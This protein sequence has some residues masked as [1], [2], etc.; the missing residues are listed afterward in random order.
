MEAML[1]SAGSYNFWLSHQLLE[2]QRVVSGPVESL[3][4]NEFRRGES[5]VRHELLIKLRGRTEVFMIPV[6]YGPAIP[7]VLKYVKL[8]DSITAYYPK[9]AMPSAR[10]PVGLIHLV[11]KRRVLLDFY[12][13]QASSRRNAIICAVG[14]GLGG[15][16][17]LLGH[18][19]RQLRRWW[20]RSAGSRRFFA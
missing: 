10:K 15:V 12:K 8:G 6:R 11:H 17:L 2:E 3:S 5:A 13:V 18:R 19:K 16:V 20:R 4:Q 7:A 1:G 14:S 9:Y